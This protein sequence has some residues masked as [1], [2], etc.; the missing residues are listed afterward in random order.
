MTAREAIRRLK[1]HFAVHDDGRPTPY[2]DE[3]VQLAYEALEWYGHMEE[4][5][6]KWTTINEMYVLTEAEI[7]E[8]FGMEEHAKEN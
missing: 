8:L 5:V 1:D 2:L 7:K 4:V 3:A 6:D